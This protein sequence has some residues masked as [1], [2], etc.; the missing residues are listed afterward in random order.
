MLSPEESLQDRPNPFLLSSVGVG[1]H[2]ISAQPAIP[3]DQPAI[4]DASANVAVFTPPMPRIGAA[5]PENMFL[6]K[7]YEDISQGRVSQTSV[8][9]WLPLLLPLLKNEIPKQPFLS[10]YFFRMHIKSI[11]GQNPEDALLIY[12]DPNTKRNVCHKCLFDVIAETCSQPH[13]MAGWISNSMQMPH[14]EGHPVNSER[15][16]QQER[17]HVRSEIANRFEHLGLV[18]FTDAFKPRHMHS[19]DSF[20]SICIG[21]VNPSRKS[22]SAEGAKTALAV[23]PSQC[24][25]NTALY[26]IIV[27]PLQELRKGGNGGI[28][29]LSEF[30]GENGKETK[31]VRPFLFAICGDDP[32]LRAVS[33]VAGH[34]N[35]D[36]T[37]RYLKRNPKPIN[38]E[39]IIDDGSEIPVW[40][41]NLDD[42]PLDHEIGP[43]AAKRRALAT[44]P[45]SKKAP[46]ARKNASSSGKVNLSPAEMT[47]IINTIPNP[48]SRIV[49]SSDDFKTC[50]EKLEELKELGK[51]SDSSSTS[52]IAPTDQPTIKMKFNQTRD[53]F[54]GLGLTSKAALCDMLAVFVFF[55]LA[56][57]KKE[58]NNGPIQSSL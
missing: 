56:K 58:T 29:E 42:P 55:S 27:K 7:L 34:M 9:S 30:A 51:N 57:E 17:Q 36:A 18:V 40:H 43:P 48:N 53:S 25:L 44:K 49:K 12:L 13:L 54:R 5:S 41:I 16:K 4:H 3:N 46:G 26:N 32:G 11:I 47:A 22:Q 52:V 35:K 45:G 33:G 37:A 15:W 1:D 10:Y 6:L 24:C 50:M 8:K 2:D 21:I 38:P 28:I 23:I 19:S 20:T 39:S 31:R 14:G